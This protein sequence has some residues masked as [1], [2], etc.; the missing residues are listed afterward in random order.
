[1]AAPRNPAGY[2]RELG[3]TFIVGEGEEGWVE[4][5]NGLSR[6]VTVVEEIDAAGSDSVA[7]MYV[8]T[9]R[10]LLL[11]WIPMKV[12]GTKS[13]RL[14]RSRGDWHGENRKASIV[15]R[16]ERERERRSGGC[17]LAQ[18]EICSKNGVG[19]F[20]WARME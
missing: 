7:A 14:G 13:K 20:S 1:M 10:S 12:C 11:L 9:A 3:E 18:D 2:C 5:C 17:R 8:L 19:G 6:E 4:I 15:S 16:R